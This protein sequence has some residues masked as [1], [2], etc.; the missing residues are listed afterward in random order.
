MRNKNTN[1]NKY[2][3]KQERREGSRG[4]ERGAGGVS[5]RSNTAE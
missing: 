5:G 2:K 1:M 4:E 3:K